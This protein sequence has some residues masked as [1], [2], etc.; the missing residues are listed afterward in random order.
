MGF[1]SIWDNIALLVGGIALMYFAI[2]RREDIGDKANWL[3]YLG[4]SL[5]VGA[6]LQFFMEY[7]V[8]TGGH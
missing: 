3:N 4:I 7:S 5:V 8:R 1:T 2:T 6:I